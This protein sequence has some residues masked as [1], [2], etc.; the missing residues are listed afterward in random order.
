MLSPK[1]ERKTKTVG[2]IQQLLLFLLDDLPYIYG[3]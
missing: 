2:V 3:W 1:F